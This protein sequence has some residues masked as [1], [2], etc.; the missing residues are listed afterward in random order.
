MQ[1][2]KFDFKVYLETETNQNISH[3]GVI[4]LCMTVSNKI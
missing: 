2:F 4:A 3:F 1:S